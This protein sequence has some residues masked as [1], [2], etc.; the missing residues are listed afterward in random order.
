MLHQM[1]GYNFLIYSSR[2]SC[3]SQSNVYYPLAPAANK[4][5]RLAGS[6]IAGKEV[7]SYP[8]IVG[9]SIFKVLDLYCSRTGI[10]LEQAFEMGFDAE[11]I[12]IENNEI[13]HYMGTKKM[14]VY[15]VFDSKSHLLLGAEITAPTALGAK[16][17]DVLATALSA[18]MKIEDIQSLDLAYAPPFAPVW[19]PILVAANIA[20][21]KLVK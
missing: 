3:L 8:G 7:S 15:L 11:S 18:K 10:S 20:S 16:K 5:G 2:K 12:L 19:D 4:Q 1:P 6:I 9:T 21:K 13:A 17:I 14:S